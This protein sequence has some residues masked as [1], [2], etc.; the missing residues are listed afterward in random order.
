MTVS[1]GTQPDGSPRYRAF[2]SYSHA[3]KA[4]A[5]WLH[6]A[7]ETYHVPAKLIGRVTA[8]GPVPRRLTPIF[9]DRDELPASGDL[10][11]ELTAA[12]RD[13]LFLIVICSPAAARSKWVG[14][15]ILTFKRMH[16]EGR[17]LALIAS[18]EPGA[19]AK[20]P[21]SPNE[22]FPRSLRLKLGPDGL[23]SAIPAEPIAA[24]LRDNA[25]GKRLALFKLYAGLTGVKLDDLVQREAQRRAR[26]LVAL[27][28]ASVTGMVFAGGLAFY[29]NTRRIEANHQREIAVREAAASRAASDYLIGTFKLSNPATENPRTVTALTILGRSAERARSELADQPAIQARLL[30]TLGS[31][32][33]NLGLFGEARKAMVGS[34][35][36]IG[37]AGPDGARVL[38]TL[39]NT[40]LQLS[41]FDDALASVKR[42]ELLLGPDLAA[43]RD[44]RGLAAATAGPILSAKGDTLA[45]V[46]A[47]DRAL[48]FLRAD[49][50]TKPEMLATV[51]NNRGLVL[52]D[53]GEI[54]RA[55]ASLLEANTRYRAVY[56]DRHLATGRSWYALA[57]NAFLAGR[58]PLAG[59]RIE[60]ALTIERG[61]LDADNP[62][63]ADALSL[64]GQIYQSENRLDDASKALSDAIGIYRAAYKMPHYQIGIAQVYLALVESGRGNT[65]KAL[66]ILDDAKHN[67]DVSY[68][69]LHA[70]HGDLLVNRATILAKTGRRA[71]AAS[72]C[73]AG[74][75]ILADTLGQDASFTRANAEICRKLLAFKSA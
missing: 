18:G 13:S 70:N 35:P 25:D 31:A 58:L 47:F 50:A 24:D 75:K 38:L 68:G 9:R 55:E 10:S 46:K 48:G 30:S 57:Q 27:T 19:S 56:G 26:R 14:E 4:V 72:D 16:G 2:I 41:R 66:K 1:A 64:Q 7:L 32:Y 54:D 40:D 6:H 29:A 74:L 5:A 42:A 21:E 36:G 34:L 67:Y 69:K 39:A 23:L 22:C 65:V 12:L 51:L 45:S 11:V 73:A 44:L 61:V 52:S 62:I 60:T 3:D 33:N 49:P 37:R 59:Q 15:E 53:A 17:I 71:E 20:D 8:I 63:L 43:H 28:T